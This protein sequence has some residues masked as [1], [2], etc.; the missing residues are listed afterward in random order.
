MTR[1]RLAVS[2]CG[3]VAI[4]ATSIWAQQ[5]VQRALADRFTQ[6]DKNGDGKISSRPQVE[7]GG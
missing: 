2:A 4:L 1:S 7:E 3:L 5:A 6:L